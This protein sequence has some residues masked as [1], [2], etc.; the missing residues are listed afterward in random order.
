MERSS[1]KPYP[2]DGTDDAW[3][4][5]TPYLVLMDEAAPQRRYAVREVF[6]GL[7]SIVR[8]RCPLALVAA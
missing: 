2:S 1:R 7:R 5:V 8:I 4:F 3:T 6:N